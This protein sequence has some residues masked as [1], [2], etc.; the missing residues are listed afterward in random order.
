MSQK[1]SKT[2]QSTYLTIRIP[3]ALALN[4]K[5]AAAK[6]AN[7]SSTLVRR[8]ITAGLREYAASEAK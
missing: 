8:F 1:Q 3:R 6:E 4:L 2:K 5:S 7:P